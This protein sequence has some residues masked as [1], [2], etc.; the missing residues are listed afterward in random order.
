MTK[1]VSNLKIEKPGKAAKT[2]KKMGA[3]QGECDDSSSFTLLNHIEEGLTVN[4]QLSRFSEYFI[5]VS[6]EFPAL[7]LDQLSAATRTK[8]SQIRQEEIP[9]IQDYQIFNIL[10]N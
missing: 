6:Q 2:S 1:A 3:K 9:Q 10:D 5:S 7:E 4:E 8:L